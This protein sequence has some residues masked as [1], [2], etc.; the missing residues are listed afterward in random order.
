MEEYIFV[1]GT[2]KRG[3]K[4]P[5]AK[6]FHERAEFVTTARTVG[7]L[8][9]LGEYPGFLL[10]GDSEIKGEVFKFKS[11]EVLAFLDK[12][13][14]VEEGLYKRVKLPCIQGIKDVWVYVYTGTRKGK[15]I[16]SGIF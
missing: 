8:I 11:P 1:Y 16:P 5:A 14:A 15:I 12:Y 13:E 7:S 3:H 9:D 6:W 2:L 10:E 4:N